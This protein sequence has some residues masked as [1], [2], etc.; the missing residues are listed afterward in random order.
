ME[1]GKIQNAG[2]LIV[3]TDPQTR[4]TFEKKNNADFNVETQAPFRQ[5]F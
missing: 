2:V 1:C 4:Q 3:Y 5:N